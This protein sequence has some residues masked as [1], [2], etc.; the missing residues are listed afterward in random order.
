MIHF[1]KIKKQ[2]EYIKLELNGYL[3]NVFGYSGGVIIWAMSL[4]CTSILIY[5]LTS[6]QIKLRANHCLRIRLNRLIKTN[7]HKDS[8]I[9]KLSFY[10]VKASLQRL[11]LTFLPTVLAIAPIFIVWDYIDHDFNSQRILITENRKGAGERALM[12]T[13][14]LFKRDLPTR[15][16]AQMGLHGAAGHSL[17]NTDITQSNILPIGLTKVPSVELK[18]Q[19]YLP[20]GPPWLRSW[21]ALFMI[22]LMLSSFILKSLFH[23]E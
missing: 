2:V 1:L 17:A 3:I 11:L 12:N 20:I 7:F 22:V 16:M 13:E 18:Q 4:S 19:E 15:P 14:L 9:L 21:T 10:L 6:P 23:I 5:F 8:I